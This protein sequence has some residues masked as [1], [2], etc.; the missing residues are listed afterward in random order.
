ME[1]GPEDFTHLLVAW[2]NGDQ[3]AGE[4]L[5]ASIYQDLRRLAQ[6]YLQ[7]E[8]RGHTLQATALVHELY[9]KLFQGEKANYQNR[10]HFFV[11]VSRQL[12]R[13]LVDHAR[14]KH[15]LKRTQDEV[16]L[17]R[18]PGASGKKRMNY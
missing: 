18:Q 8:S 1:I 13:L 9:L 6:S 3:E 7:Q 16:T 2:K 17:D 15:A 14:S 10:S 4:R 11:I 5:F 12:R